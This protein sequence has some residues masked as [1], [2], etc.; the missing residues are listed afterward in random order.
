MPFV[1]N[2]QKLLKAMENSNTSPPWSQTTLPLLHPPHETPPTP[3][4]LIK[5]S[6]VC[7]TAQPVEEYI[8]LPGQVAVMNVW[9][10][11]TAQS[12]RKLFRVERAQIEKERGREREVGGHSEHFEFS[13]LSAL[14]ADGT[15]R[16]PDLSPARKH[17]S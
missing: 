6:N 3:L 16:P 1:L 4:T 5:M 11:F 12:P 15:Q 13:V 8:I 17:T 9:D 2:L 7:K 10:K 14:G